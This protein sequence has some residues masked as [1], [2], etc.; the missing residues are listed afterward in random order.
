MKRFLPILV[1]TL[2]AT[3]MLAGPV[4]AAKPGTGGLTLND[5][6]GTIAGTTNTFVGDV[7]LTR[8]SAQD[9]ELVA[10]GTIVGTIRD[11]SGALVQAVNDTFTTTL[12]VAGATCD[13]LDLS[14][15]PLDLDLL[16]LV[17]HLD[18]VNLT[19]DAQQGPG[20]L[21]GNLLCA[22]AGLLD[23]PG[24]LSGLL[25]QVAALLNQILSILG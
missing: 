22:I 24:G 14:L 8:V 6:T 25:N 5:V 16:G 21:L 17:V 20:N 7:T 9:G 3:L 11:A 19:I 23:S 15:G 4:S 2:V 18:E 13:I 12:S 10:T 1:A